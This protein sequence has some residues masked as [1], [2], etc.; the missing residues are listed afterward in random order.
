MLSIVLDHTFVY[1]RCVS[2]YKDGVVLSMSMTMAAKQARGKK[3]NDVIFAAS[4]AAQSDIKLNGKDHVVNG[5]VGSILDE[6]G[7]IVFLQSVKE[8]YL[9]LPNN[10]YIAYAPIAGL[11]EY[12][13]AVYKACFEDAKPDAYIDAVATAGGTGGIHHLV[14]NYTALGDTVLTADWYWG[15]YK[16]ICKDSGRILSTFTLLTDTNE[17]NIDSFK[18]EVM[19]L[20][21]GQENLLI[22]LNTPGNNPTGFSISD[23]SWDE[24]L[25]FLSSLVASTTTKII[26]GVDVAYLDYAG[27]KHAVRQFFKKF[28]QLP[29]EILTVICYSVSKGFTMYGQRLGAM[30]GIS[31]NQDVIDEFHE[32]NAITSRATWSNLCRPAQRTIANLVSD[33]KK[34]AAYEEEREAYNSLIHER[35]AIFVEEA[36]SCGLPLLPYKG[37]FFLTIPTTQSTKICDVLKEKHIYVIPLV[38]GIR[39]AACSIPKKQMKG[40]A[41]SIY[42]T[43]KELHSL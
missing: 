29:K 19:H 43:M 4:S 39:V 35:A 17:F 7:Q 36:K 26:L 25:A 12:L 31:S 5:T 21:K 11:P 1:D 41:L 22:L 20:S 18:E 13:S 8:E 9:H 32:I 38:K 2:S 42:D 16:T 24:I 10:E 28:S 15:N 37:G 27:E 6:D 34:F 33:D 3:Q 30:I 14:H 40:L 23:T